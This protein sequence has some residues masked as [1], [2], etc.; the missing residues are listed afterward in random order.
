MQTDL[1]TKVYF[2][3]HLTHSCVGIP[4]GLQALLSSYIT[5]RSVR[6]YYGLSIAAPAARRSWRRE[7]SNSKNIQPISFK[8][9]M[10][11]D[12]HFALVSPKSSKCNI[13]ISNSPIAFKFYTEVKYLKLHKINCQWLDY[14]PNCSRWRHFYPPSLLNAIS[15]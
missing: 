12:M 13:S 10:W 11:V 2:N 8:F 3:E 5:E 6:W 15:P 1:I 14:R 7:H 9:Y 4:Q